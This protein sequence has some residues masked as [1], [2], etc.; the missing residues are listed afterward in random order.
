[1]RIV[2]P[3][4]L[5]DL[6]RFWL[7]MVL[8]CLRA[9]WRG[10]PPGRHAAVGLSAACLRP[11]QSLMAFLLAMREAKADEAPWRQYGQQQA[12]IGVEQLDAQG[13]GPVPSS[14]S[15]PS[16]GV[17]MPMIS[18]RPQHQQHQREAEPIMKPS[19]AASKGFLEA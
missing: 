5:Q 15:A 18:R 13:L 14:R 4:S 17:P 3:Q 11:I 8:S 19:T 12:G 1:M 7:F 16:N 2:V 10:R 9:G 6:L